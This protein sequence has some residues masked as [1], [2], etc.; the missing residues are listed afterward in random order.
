MSTCLQVEVRAAP[1]RSTGVSYLNWVL[2]DMEEF[3]RKKGKGWGGKGMMPHKDE[4][5]CVY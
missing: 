4:M 2:K 1:K 5:Q 3:T